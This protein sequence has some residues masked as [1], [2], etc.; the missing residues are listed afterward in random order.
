MTLFLGNYQHKIDQKGRLVMPRKLMEE[1]QGDHKSCRFV[2]TLGL[3]PCLYLFTREGFLEH[4]Q[5]VRQAAFGD[6]EFRDV[7]RGV[8]HLS[9]E[10]VPDSHGRIQI[11]AEL[12]KRVGLDTEVTVVGVVDH[13]EVWNR[14]RWQDSASDEAEN[15]YLER[16][17]RYFLSGP[18]NPGVE[19]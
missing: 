17:D 12:R 10:V 2:V 5:H 18:P 3:D 11:P 1:A 14:K 19:P 4:V 8:G 13:I 9:V 15:T 6:P 7:M 16:A